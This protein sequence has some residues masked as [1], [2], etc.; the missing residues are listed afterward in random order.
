MK[1]KEKKGKRK[2][3]EKKEENNLSCIV[4]NFSFWGV[5][6]IWKKEIINII[7]IIWIF[8]LFNLFNTFIGV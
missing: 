6:L 3:Q 1:S 8:Y 7:G 4:W 2:I 5:Y